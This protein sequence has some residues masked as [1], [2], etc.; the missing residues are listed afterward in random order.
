TLSGT[1]VVTVGGVASL[2]GGTQTG[3]GTTILSGGGSINGNIGLDEG[4]TLRIGNGINPSTV[5]WTGGSINLNAG[6]TGNAQAGILSTAVGGVLNATSN[7]LITANNFGGVEDGSSARFDN[8]GTFR[9][10]AGTGSTLVQVQFNNTG[11][12]QVQS[13]TVNLSG[14]GTHTGSFDVST[15]ATLQFGG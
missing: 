5:D 1:G 6:G 14:G 4:R 15:G 12:V 8:A 9:K 2:S 3:T 10:S 7:N 13:G 11:T